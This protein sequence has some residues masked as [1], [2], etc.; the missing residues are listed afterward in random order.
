MDF[1]KTTLMVALAGNTLPTTGGPQNLTAGQVGVYRPDYSVASAANI[2]A[3]NYIYLAQGRDVAVPGLGSKR[4]DKIYTKNIID[5]YKV[6]GSATANVQTTVI[7][8]ITGKCD[9]T[10]TLTLRLFSKYINVGFYNGLTR[11]VT[12][13]TPCC[14]C[15][16][17]NCADV[18]TADLVA[19][20]VAEINAE[21][22]L[23]QFLTATV[24]GVADDEITITGKALDVYGNA[25]D[26][27]S[28]PYQYDRMYF[29]TFLHRG[30]ET[31]QDFEVYD[32]CDPFGTAT[33]TQA[34]SYPKNVPA[35]IRQMEKDYYSYQT[36]YKD[37]YSSP[38]FNGAFSSLVSDSVAAYDLLYI[39]FYEPRNMSF[40]DEA[41]QEEMVIIAAPATEAAAII[42]RLEL[43]FGSG[44]FIEKA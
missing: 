11:S 31:T 4:S 26:L 7:T 42:T 37:I 28:F 34:S 33:V 14:D 40:T 13:K 39:R 21:P 10:L 44:A 1:Q 23:S 17:D 18:D 5:L 15:G 12:I 16:A 9:E 6:T 43:F 27:N 3:A 29:K 38:L 24:T 32:A 36:I 20:F 19:Q 30:P 35:Q 2:A 22:R 41:S 8:G 25:C